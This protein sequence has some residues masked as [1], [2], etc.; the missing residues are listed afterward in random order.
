MTWFSPSGLRLIL[1]AVLFGGA[2]VVLL[3]R[4]W[5]LQI[6]KREY[7]LERIPGA[8]SVTVR[9]P[10]TRGRIFDRNGVLLAENTISYEALCLFGNLNR[11]EMVD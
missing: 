7:F 11:R 4:L 6:K 5:S 8:S 1:L 2:V 10:P 3:A 9:V